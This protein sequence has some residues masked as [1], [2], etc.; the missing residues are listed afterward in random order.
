MAVR[1]RSYA[2]AVA[3]ASM[4]SARGVAVTLTAWGRGWLVVAS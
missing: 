3:Y 1:Y 4:L 2:A